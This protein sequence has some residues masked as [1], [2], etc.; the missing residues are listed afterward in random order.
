MKRGLGKICVRIKE[1]TRPSLALGSP[2]SAWFATTAATHP[3][4]LFLRSLQLPLISVGGPQ[5]GR[6]P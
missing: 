3:L 5:A 1:G 6:F 2:A 4:I